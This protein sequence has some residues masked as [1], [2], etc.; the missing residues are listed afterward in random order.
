MTENIKKSTFHAPV[1]ILLS[2]LL[3]S[4]T[5]LMGWLYYLHLRNLRIH[6]PEYD[7]VAIVQKNAQSEALKTMYLAQ[8]LDLSFD[9]PVNIYQFD[10]DEGEKKLN[11][12]PVIKKAHIKKI[13][14]GILYID[15]QV[16]T[17]MAYLGNYSNTAIDQEG[18]I[19]PF[20]PFF[21]PKTLPSFYLKNLNE[22]NA[23][24]T[25]LKYNKEFQLA[26]KVLKKAEVLTR[27]N[28]IITQIDVSQA[29]LES[30]G[31]RQIVMTLTQQIGKN[32]EK[33]ITYLRLNTDNYAQNIDNY[34]TLCLQKNQSKTYEK[35]I[36]FRIPHLAFIENKT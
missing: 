23:W 28:I 22:K 32:E 19:F 5:A 36:D 8:L 21:T 18:N 30:Y 15:Y 14:P 34:I 9:R 31:Q 25:S 3:I 11:A 24:G 6:D 10:E 13:R 12:S 1:W 29:Y 35:I 27:Q 4:G 20:R 33:M 17:P 16:R 26:L 2:I 7:I